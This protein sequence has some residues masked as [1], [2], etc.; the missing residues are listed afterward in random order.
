[1]KKRDFQR[2]GIRAVSRRFGCSREK[3]WQSYW[4]PLI[5]GREGYQH[6]IDGYRD[7]GRQ[8]GRKAPENF[9]WRGLFLYVLP[10]GSKLWR[11]ACRFN[12]KQKTL[13]VGI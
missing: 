5:L 1:L 4:Y 6:G 11:L 9:R 13:A 7:Q 8:G 12:G 3:C 10:T 2:N